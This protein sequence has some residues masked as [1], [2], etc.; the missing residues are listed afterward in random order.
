[1]AANTAI[2]KSSRL[3]V[4]L[5]SLACF[6]PGEILGGEGDRT[7]LGPAERNASFTLTI[8]EGLLSLTAREASL[9]EILNAIGRRMR[10]EVVTRVPADETV[11]I[12]IDRLPL[13]AALRRLSRYANIAHISHQEAGKGQGRIT[14]ITAFPK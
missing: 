6:I 14:Q 3:I 8:D 11:T 12:A 2:N 7:L 13:E 9:K 4:F 5:F 1:M 10:I